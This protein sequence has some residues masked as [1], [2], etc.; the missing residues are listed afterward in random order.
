L[1]RTTARR[2]EIARCRRC[3]LEF[4]SPM[5]SA[6][7]LRGFYPIG[8][9]V[10]PP[11]QARG[12]SRLARLTEVYRRA[13]LLD[14]VRFV[15]PL[16]A[17]Q[18]RLGTWRGLLDVGCGDGSFLAACAA[19]PGMGLDSSEAALRAVQARGFRAVLGEL[20]RAP[21]HDGAFSVVTLFHV[22]E[23][24]MPSPALQTV[25]RILSRGGS[26]VVQVPNVDAWQARLLGRRWAGYDPPRHL[27]DYSAHT[28]RAMLE[29]HGFRVVRESQY[30]LRDNPTTVANSLAPGL[31]PPA[32]LARGSASSGA[33]EWGAR[34]G[35][36]ALVLVAL[37][38]TL[39]ESAL[40]H[41]ASVMMEAR[42]G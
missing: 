35:Y 39:V 5:P 28:L 31:Y 38:L 10:G 6:E 23:H 7:E 18:R 15:R 32:R 12:A 20:D 25:R 14:H 26:L 3:R 13:A 33:A 42:P 11:R 36:L 4:L 1:F 17:D 21:I 29:R 8:Y 2:F 40:G 37:P 27:V 30:S 19:H 41:G 22:L 9:W 24:V 16:L 34:L